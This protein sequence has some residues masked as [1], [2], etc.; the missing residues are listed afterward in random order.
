MS[1]LVC[2]LSVA[3][4]VVAAAA[5]G[6][7]GVPAAADSRD[8]ARGDEADARSPADL[9][10]EV[11][12]AAP[13]DLANA[14][15]PELDLAMPDLA[16]PD[17]LVL[18]KAAVFGPPTS[19]QTGAQPFQL[20]LG[21][22][23]GDN[24]LDLVSSGFNLK[25]I[26]VHLS[27]N[28]GTFRPGI[29]STAQNSVWMV[30]GGDFD[31]DGALDLAVSTG[32][33]VLMMAGDKSGRFVHRNSTVLFGARGLAAVDFDHDGLLDVVVA[34]STAVAVLRGN[35]DGTLRAPEEAPAC[36]RSIYAV[37][38]T[39]LDNDGWEEVL[40][41]DIPKATLC[42]HPA[43][44]GGKLGPPAL[45]PIGSNA[46]MSVVADLDRDGNLDIATPNGVLK[47][48]TASVLLG[49]GGLKFGATAFYDTADY[50][51]SMAVADF[52]LDRKPDLAI[53]AYDGNAITLLRGFGNGTFARLDL[54]SPKQPVA[55]VSHDFN[56][57]GKPDIAVLSGLS[58]D[59]S[60]YL[61]VTK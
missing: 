50:P 42:V 57:D 55:V 34:G 47:P 54:P 25:N 15:Q 3:A 21:D 61:N 17:L 29:A 14:V 19:Y 9:S 32:G 12:D 26:T 49:S 45:L 7:G 38:V 28:D 40:A 56:V 46:R 41:I 53:A 18:P 27:N 58:E 5:C 13:P 59:V 8:A 20:T 44:G 4:I 2:R 23:D 6:D 1:M 31:R 48:P 51:L 37:T 22:V 52:N 11:L 33:A 30:A 43:L 39:D 60:I 35:G 24:V 16:R 10:A 36:G